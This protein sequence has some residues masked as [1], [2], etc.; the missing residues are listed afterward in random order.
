MSDVKTSRD[1]LFSHSHGLHLRPASLIT[2]LASQYQSRIELINGNARVDGK[3]ILDLLTL[4]AEPGTTLVI[5]ATGPDAEAA[6]EALVA[7][8]ATNFAELDNTT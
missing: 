1:V 7:L 4:G 6:V 5:E 3:S 2:K 8:I